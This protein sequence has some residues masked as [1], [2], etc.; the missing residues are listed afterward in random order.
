[1]RAG[2]AAAAAGVTIK[3]LRYYEDCGLLSPSR[4]ANGYRDYTVEDV[5]LAEEIRS[6]GALGLTPKE[7][8]VVAPVRMTPRCSRRINPP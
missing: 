5:R 3:A 4:A 2:E 7:T 1:M 6:L 8:G